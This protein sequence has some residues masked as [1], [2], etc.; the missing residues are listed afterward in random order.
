M[1]S[2]ICAVGNSWQIGLEE[3]L[4]WPH[5]KD[6][7]KWYRDITTCKVMV[8]GWATYKP[9]KHVEWNLCRQLITADQYR[10]LETPLPDK[11]ILIGGA[12][13]YRSFANQIDQLYLSRID[14]DG[15]AD[16][17]FPV[18]AFTPKQIQNA[19]WRE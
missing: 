6:D 16:T 10:E 13:T 2:A 17:F 19:I 4:P 18:D 12:K 11:Y 9:L 1:I 5:H 3:M 14:Y 7:L 8:A 15:P